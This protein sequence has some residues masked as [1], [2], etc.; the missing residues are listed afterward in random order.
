MTA[1]MLTLRLG[2]VVSRRSLKRGSLGNKLPTLRVPPKKAEKKMLVQDPSQLIPQ[3]TPKRGVF[4]S[5]LF[6]R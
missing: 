2:N 5:A 1:S 6:C 4:D 3:N